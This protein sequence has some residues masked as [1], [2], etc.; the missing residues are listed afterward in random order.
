MVVPLLNN[1]GKHFFTYYIFRRI[2]LD[3]EMIIQLSQIVRVLHIFGNNPAFKYSRLYYSCHNN[4]NTCAMQWRVP[5]WRVKW[6]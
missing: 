6:L 2:V 5:V 4:V 3:C 1:H